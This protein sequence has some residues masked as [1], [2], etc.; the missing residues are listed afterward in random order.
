MN[1]LSAVD[2]RL[3]KDLIERSELGSIEFHEVSARRFD[4]VEDFGESR[5]GGLTLGFQQRSE[6]GVFGI[7]IVGDI[8]IPMGEAR[9]VAAAEYKVLRGD[10]PPQRLV[11]L[12]ANEVAIMTLFPYL[13]EG[14]ASITSKVFGTPITLP[15]AQ[16][17]QIGF[18]VTPAEQ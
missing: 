16:R 6:T 11:E 5:D 2:A 15:V 7:R 9:V 13:R 8:A 10:L 1:E 17:G 12:F 14:I 3:V 4:G 18:E